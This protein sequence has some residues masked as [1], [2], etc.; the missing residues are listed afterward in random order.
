MKKLYELLRTGRQLLAL[1]VKSFLVAGLLSF[2]SLISQDVL[3]KGN[4]YQEEIAVTGNV[5]DEEGVAIPGVNIL[6]K[7]TS[8]GTVSDAN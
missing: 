1:D 3:A 4:M 8:N 7:G 5:T 2:V 6:E